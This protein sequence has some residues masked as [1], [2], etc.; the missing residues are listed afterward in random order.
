MALTGSDIA[1]FTATIWDNKYLSEK[2]VNDIVKR[3][4]GKSDEKPRLYGTA[5]RKSGLLYAMFKEDIHVVPYNTEFIEKKWPVIRAID[6]HP[7]IP[8][9]ITWLAINPNGE[10]AIV[11]EL[12]CPENAT[13]KRCATL[14]KA[15]EYNM[16]IIYGVID[17]S[18]N[19][20]QHQENGRVSKTDKQLFAQESIVCRNAKKEWDYGHHV[21][22]EAL[23]GVEITN[24]ETG[25]KEIYYKFHIYDNC[26]EV[27]YQFKH[28]AWKDPANDDVDGPQRQ[29]KKRDH[30]IDLVRYELVEYPMPIKQTNSP[31]HFF[32][33][34]GRG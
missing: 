4:K 21:V 30:M 24:R 34:P 23:Q 11:D 18:S 8:I 32:G 14:I 17:T 1:C 20:K 26:I 31:K 3:W 15:K 12:V 27:I 2:A 29:V 33:G 25:A 6:S 9:H 10:C 22:Q 16:N 5:V 19:T 13:I 28:C 7:Q